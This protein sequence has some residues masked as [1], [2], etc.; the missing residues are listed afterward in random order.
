MA[1]FVTIDGTEIDL[2]NPCAV[3]SAL[4]KVELKV[5][6]GGGVVM[7]RFGDDEVRWSATN[8]SG[9]RDLIADYERRCAA[10]TGGR[11]RYA[12]RLRFVR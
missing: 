7:T 1:D 8:L 9:L 12:K 10:Q 6:T 11:T 4:R 5:A 2:E 3:A